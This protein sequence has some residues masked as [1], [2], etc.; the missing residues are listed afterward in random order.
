MQMQKANPDYG[1]GINPISRLIQIQQAKKECE[2][3]YSVIEEK[4]VP[5][6]REFVVQVSHH[7]ITSFQR[8]SW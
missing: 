5:R 8:F 6:N 2:P 4:G 1:A 3:A 7:L